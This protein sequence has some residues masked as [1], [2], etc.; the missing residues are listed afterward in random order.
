MANDTNYEYINEDSIDPGLICAICAEPF[1]KP[2]CTPCGH[3]FCRECITTVINGSN[4]RCPICRSRLESVNSLAPVTHSVRNMLDRL[5]II[6]GICG[7]TRLERGNFNHHVNQN[8]PQMRVSCPSADIGCSWM[9]PRGQLAT[10][11]QTCAVQPVQAKLTELTTNVRLLREQIRQQRD[12]IQQQD[13]QIKELRDRTRQHD[14]K[15]T[16]QG[17]QVQHQNNQIRQ[18]RDR[19]QQQGDQTR[20]LCDRIQQQNN[21]ISEQRDQIRQ[22]NNQISEQRDQIR[23]QNNQI[24]EQRDQIRQQNNQ[25]SEQRDQIRQHDDQMKLFFYQL[26]GK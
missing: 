23:Q 14:D 22:Q 9:G 26:F 20:E 11:L 8:C 12:R 18:Q 7:T 2:L 17:D 21:Q 5:P 3:I 25:I 15:I 19:I 6:C 16:Q 13:D 1:R 10:H 24:S 4:R